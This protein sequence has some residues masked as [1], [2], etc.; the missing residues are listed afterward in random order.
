MKTRIA[1]VAVFILSV[2]MIASLLVSCNGESVDETVSSFGTTN[3]AEDLTTEVP[4]EAST[5]AST[6]APTDVPTK[7]PTEEPT[8][9]PTEEITTEVPTEEITTEAPL[10]EYDIYSSD[11][12]D[13]MQNMFDG[14][15]VLNETVMFIDYGDR[16]TLMYRADD[17]ISV[18]SY[19][20]SVTYTE[21]VDY[22]LEDGG[23]VLLEG[24]SIPCIT[25]EVYYNNTESDYLTIEHNGEICSVYWGDGTKMTQWQVN[26]GVFQ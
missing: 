20:G 1:H 10:L 19:D 12:D 16:K 25:S 26:V 9:A 17:I 14:N 5:E 4:T 15:Q 2:V 13:L 7:A 3:V 21:G 22:A 11:L 6:E 18:T 23:I 8:E 24:S